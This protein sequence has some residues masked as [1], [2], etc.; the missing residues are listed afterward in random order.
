M[1]RRRNIIVLAVVMLTVLGAAAFA[2]AARNALAIFNLTPTNMEAMGYD[3][4]ILYALLSALEREKTIELMPR[5]EMEEILFHAGLVQGGDLESIAKAGKALGIN[6]VLFGNVTK[7]AGPI[8]A[9]LKLMDVQNKRLIKTWDKSFAGREA[10]LNEIPAF[11]KELNSAIVNREQTYAVP[12]AAPVQVA[13]DIE[14]LRAKSD[15]DKVVLTWKFDP[16]QPIVGFNVYRSEHS[17]G[18]YQF[19]GRTNQNLFD[20]TQINKGKSY[21]YRIGI[22]LS[23]GDEIKSGLTTQIKSAGEKIPHPPLIMSGQGCVRR[24]EI[25]FVPSLLNDQEKFKLDGYKVYRKKSSGDS[26]ENLASI[27]AKMESQSELA[28]NVEDSKNLEDGETYFYAVSSLD[29]K[30]RE[31]PLS[32]PVSVKTIQRPVLTVEKDNLLRKTDLAWQPREGV[33]GYYLYRKRAQAQEDW[34]NVAKIRADSEARYTDDK[35]LEDGQTYQYSLTVY[36][37]KA[38]SGSSKTVQAKTKDRPPP[39]Q[40]VLSQSGLVKSVKIFWTPVDDPDVDGY[41]I[42]RGTKADDLKRIAKAKGYQSHSYLDK[43]AGYE[44]LEDGRDYFYA[45]VSYNL[46]G[47]DGEPTK[48]VKA[49]TK[50]RPTPVKGFVATKGSDFINIKWDKNP[51]PDIRAYSL[52]RSRNGGYW[53]TLKNL[54]SDQTSFKD[55][56]LRPETDYRYRIIVQDNDSLE[57]DPVESEA[58]ASP[59]ER[60]KK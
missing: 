26:W 45:I 29:D 58:V 7:K 1:L 59:I 36:D 16:S 42:Y 56:D 4:E 9:Q 52:A 24:A 54:D 33:F 43:G 12:G 55:M 41:A 8:L 30:E 14:N 44:P 3:G 28:F 34:Q 2:E 21:Y 57:S 37:A 60:P 46:F 40:D 35:G 5:R 19:H 38:E 48:A 23:S 31:S 27:S 47:A 49:T 6:F 13:V 15:G 25:K 32:D 18:F 11:A 17:E 10:I 39:P 22:M 20:D 51:E 50:P 53:S